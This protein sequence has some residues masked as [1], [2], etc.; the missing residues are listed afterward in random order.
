VSATPRKNKIGL[1][2]GSGGIKPLGLISLF[3][4]L[5]ENNLKPDI[6][7]GCSG[8]S[9]L[10]S[11][12]ASGMPLSQI[13]AL[14]LEYQDLLKN[15]SFM[16]IIDYRTLLSLANYPGGR[17]DQSSGIL[18]KNWLLDFFMEKLDQRRLEDCLVKNYMM[19][20][21]LETGEPVALDHGLIAECMYASCA[22]YPVLPPLQ[23]NNRWL[24][25]GAYH[26]ALPILEAMKRGCDKII[27]V[28]FEEK[29]SE[30]QNSFF[31]FYMEFVSQVLNKNARK[32]NSFAVHFHHDEIL[33]INCYFDKAINFWD[34]GSLA[35]INNTTNDIIQ[36]NKAAI[37]EMFA[38]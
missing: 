29:R 38:S 7:V 5:E 24:V 33:F 32:Q 8:G 13:E 26:S 35:F 15:Q 18:S 14:I 11:A 27:A 30:K 4:M 1:V 2:I 34:V 6:I 28:S 17:F 10:S 31:E 20:T 9:I 3:R 22:M 25:D 21:D 16:K 23:I 12:W 19:A 36:K 37:L